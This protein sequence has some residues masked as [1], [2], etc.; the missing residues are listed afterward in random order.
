MLWHAAQQVGPG[1][2]QRALLASYNDDSTITP[3]ISRAMTTFVAKPAEIEKKWVLIDAAGLIVGRVASLIALRLRGKHL[4]TFTPHVDCGD[5]VIVVNALITITIATVISG[6]FLAGV[7]KGTIESQIE[8]VRKTQERQLANFD[9]LSVQVNQ[10]AQS[11]SYIQGLFERQ[12]TA[13]PRKTKYGASLKNQYKKYL[14][15]DSEGNAVP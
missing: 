15:L 5:N 10:L 14:H 8:E 11:L 1:V 6:I 12:D 7:W 3:G 9:R 4:P 13:T 2:I